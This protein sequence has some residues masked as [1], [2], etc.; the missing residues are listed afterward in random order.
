MGPQC[1]RWQPYMLDYSA[2]PLLHY[3]LSQCNICLFN[4][5]NLEKLTV[6]TCM[7]YTYFE[8]L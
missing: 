1:C 4:L 2:K 5:K 7:H 3:F 6:L 8:F